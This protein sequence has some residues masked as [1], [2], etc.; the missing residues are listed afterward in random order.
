MTGRMTD[1]AESGVSLPL[2]H[3]IQALVD[4][5]LVDG[6]VTLC[7]LLLEQGVDINQST[8][9]RILRKLGAVKVKD[10]SGRVRYTIPTHM[11]PPSVDAPLAQLVTEVI[12][13]SQLIVVHTRPGAASLIASII[14]HHRAHVGA[15]GIVAGDDTFFV[16]PKSPEII[17][18]VHRAVL[19]LLERLSL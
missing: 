17:S 4:A 15:A 7:R 9:S 16:A 13:T 10:P 14:D 2:V 1:T 18:K 3:R 11:A 8:A 5:G 19:R 12:N 6:Q